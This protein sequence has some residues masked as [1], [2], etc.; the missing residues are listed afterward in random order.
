[1]P[2]RLH[3]AGAGLYAGHQRGDSAGVGSCSAGQRLLPHETQQRHC[4]ALLDDAVGMPGKLHHGCEGPRALHHGAL[5]GGGQTI[6]T[7]DAER[8]LPCVSAQRG[9]AKHVRQ[10]VV[11]PLLQRQFG[12]G[13]EPLHHARILLKFLSAR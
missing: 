11:D 13:F 10:H 7:E 5:E 8:L 4:G 12:H 6:E 1:M 9:G 3:S 2:A